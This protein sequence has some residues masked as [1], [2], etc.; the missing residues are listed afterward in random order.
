M[1]DGIE[2]KILK[3]IIKNNGITFRS[4]GD[5]QEVSIGGDFIEVAKE[6][7]TVLDTIDNEIK[8]GGE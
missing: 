8:W 3:K 1:K 5:K 2:I 6:E 7:M 4:I